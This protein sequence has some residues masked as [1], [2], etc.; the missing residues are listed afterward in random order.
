MFNPA[1]DDFRLDFG[2]LR[3]QMN[4]HDLCFLGLDPIIYSNHGNSNDVP[5][6]ATSISWNPIYYTVN[7]NTGPSTVI[8][9]H[10]KGYFKSKP[11]G[12][13]D[14]GVWIC[15]DVTSTNARNKCSDRFMMVTTDDNSQI[16]PGLP[17]DNESSLIAVNQQTLSIGLDR[18]QA[19]TEVEFG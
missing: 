9:L 10:D 14:P 7:E 6:L 16:L 11:S 1:S 3:Q 12:W 2:S 15:W 18:C 19:T 4:E 17:D 13:K 5:N 8:T